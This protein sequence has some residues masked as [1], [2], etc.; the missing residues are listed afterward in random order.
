[1]EVGKA[2]IHYNDSGEGTAIVCLHGASSNARDMEESIVPL[3]AGDFRVVTVDR[4]GLGH[5]TRPGKDWWSPLDQANAVREVL[6]RLGIRRPVLLGHSWSGAVVLS[7]LLQY[8][9]EVA[10]AI[11]LSPATRAW[12]LPPAL[13]NRISRWPLAGTLFVRLLVLPI[14]SLVMGAGVR[15]VF[16]RG[17]TPRDYRQRTH[18]NMLLRPD[19]WRANAD[20]LC[21]LN[22]YLKENSREYGRIRHPLL[23]IIGDHDRVVSNEIHT[24]GLRQQIPH[25]QI[26][27]IAQSGHLPHHEEPEAVARLIRR[28]CRNM[29]TTSS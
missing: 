25:L 9:G 8:P 13:S 20:D 5:S 12:N 3:L 10:G 16:H 17:K 28:F 27:S 18:L 29:E 14:G 11:L 26:V 1:M 15:S 4:P 2:R 6:Q 7:Y 23:A 19:T 21:R 22:D 24:L